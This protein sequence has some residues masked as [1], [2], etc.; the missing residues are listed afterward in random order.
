MSRD[1][2]LMTT[3]LRAWLP[4][5]RHLTSIVAL[6]TG[7][8]N[9]TYL[10]EG[11]DAVLR[12]PPSE[13]GLL[14]P[15]DMTA[16]YA[17]LD[18]VSQVVGGPPV[19]RVRALCEDPTVLGDPFFVMDRAPGESFDHPQVP[20]WLLAATPEV[21]GEM[22]R[23]WL[24]AVVAVSTIPVQEMVGVPVR[25]PAEEAAHW[26]AV[27][28]EVDAPEALLV[29][30]DDLVRHPPASSGAL[31]AVHGD[32]RHANCLW[33]GGRLTAF[34]DWELAQVGDPMLDLGNV[35]AYFP[36]GLTPAITAGFD[37]DGWWDRKQVI[38]AWELGTGRDAV[39]AARWEG[40]AMSRLAAILAVG[41]HLFDTGQATDLRFQTWRDTLPLYLQLIE[42][43]LVL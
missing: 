5:G 12:M 22:C 38:E 9:E 27:A 17:L 35:L 1:L 3:Q 30:L 29:L 40:L 7:H 36:D 34:V 13:V 11:C 2:D 21:R 6:S 15:Y 14:P 43:R 16:Q 31:T 32:T 39:D 10:L 4:D 28:R 24:A 26:A 33:S 19:P 42:V 18:R 37:L 23:Q 41:A 20:S 8:S 25:L